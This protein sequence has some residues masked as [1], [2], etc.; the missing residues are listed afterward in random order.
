MT[1]AKITQRYI[2]R[3]APSPSGPLHFGSL[4][5]ALASYLDAK[6]QGGLWRVRIDDI[7]PPR[8]PEGAAA[9]ILRTLED[10]GLQWDGAV[11]YQSQR[12]DDYQTVVAQLAQEHC[13]YYCTC[14][15]AMLKGLE[16]YPGT[17]KGQQ[18]PTAAAAIRIVMPNTPF[19]LE[20][21]LQ[22]ICQ[23]PAGQQGDWIIKRKDGLWAYQFATALDD[24]QD[25]ISHVVRGIDL[26]DTTYRQIWLQKKLGRIS[27]VYAHLP[28][29][30]D[31]L[32]KKLS[33]QNW[34]KP[35]SHYDRAQCMTAAC[36]LLG[37]PPMP[38]MAEKDWL[39]WAV[40]EW[41]IE[42]LSGIRTVAMPE[43]LLD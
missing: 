14:T 12:R 28:V 30:V 17:C 8:T 24:T 23:C 34:A 32:G 11:I 36:T 31:Q 9:D 35:V 6:S 37:L 25:N 13:L 1:N 27:P 42:R 4:L 16:A 21:R 19:M 3:F 7:D 41:N 38:N 43:S 2:G 10:F 40:S 39:A 22:G 33:K 20:D 26:L 29:V 18:T 5:T 15:R